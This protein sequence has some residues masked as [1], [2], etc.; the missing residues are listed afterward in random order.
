MANDEG[1]AWPSVRSLEARTGLSDRTIQRSLAKLVEEGLVVRNE[2]AGRSTVY[3]VLP[4]LGEA[5]TATVERPKSPKQG[6]QA[7]TP[8]T[9]SPP[10]QCH[11]PPDTVT[12]GGDTVSPHPRHSVTQIHQGSS[13][14]NQIDPPAREK[15]A[16]DKFNPATRNTEPDR[17]PVADREAARKHLAAAKAKAAEPK[18]EVVH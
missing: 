2:R 4:G 10:T 17:T 16:V 3:Q 7:V 8:D 13:Y 5:V 18:P 14:L 1:H 12:E 6:R 15:R 11:P 9:V